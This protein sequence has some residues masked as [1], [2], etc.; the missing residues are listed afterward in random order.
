[1]R[2]SR[3]TPGPP[4]H[5]PST[6]SELAERLPRIQAE[7][8]NASPPGCFGRDVLARSQHVSMARLAVKHPSLHF[9]Q[10]EARWR[11]CTG[12]GGTRKILAPAPGR[13][14]LIPV[15]GFFVGRFGRCPDADAR[16]RPLSYK[17][18]SQSDTRPPPSYGASSCGRIERLRFCSISGGPRRECRGPLKVDPREGEHTRCPRQMPGTFNLTCRHC[19]PRFVG[20]RSFTLDCRKIFLAYNST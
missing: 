16:P 11:R 15:Q 3:F 8:T 18:A 12:P 17:T 9:A 20:S 6:P 14:S 19:S 1:M 10:Q 4:S 13:K 7:A 2:P 5:E